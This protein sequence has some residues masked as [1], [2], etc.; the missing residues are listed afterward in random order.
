MQFRFVKESYLLV[1]GEAHVDL[2]TMDQEV[3]VRAL[4]MQAAARAPAIARGSVIIAGAISTAG[5]KAR[6]V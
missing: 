1:D 3:L 4:L 5:H 6:L 2:E